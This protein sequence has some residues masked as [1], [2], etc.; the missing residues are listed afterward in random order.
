MRENDLEFSSLKFIFDF[1]VDVGMKLR[2]FGVFVLA[3][4]LRGVL[5]DTPSLRMAFLGGVEY[6]SRFSSSSKIKFFSF[7]VFLMVNLS[8]QVFLSS[9]LEIAV[10]KSFSA[11][12]LTMLSSLV[13]FLTSSTATIGVLVISKMGDLKKNEM[14]KRLRLRVMNSPWIRQFIK[15][16][17]INRGN[18][19]QILVRIERILLFRRK[20]IQINLRFHRFVERSVSEFRARIASEHCDWSSADKGRGAAGVAIPDIFEDPCFRRCR[21]S[22]SFYLLKLT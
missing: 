5:V 6:L 11:S 2:D 13:F 1:G 3:T 4:Q 12:F 21:S 16:F 17:D 19:R 8:S 15:V 10:D 18:G 22:W 7:L 14:S 20:N 9:S